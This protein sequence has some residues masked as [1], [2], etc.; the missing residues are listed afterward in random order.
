M[1]DVI[2]ILLDLKDR[3]ERQIRQH[4]CGGLTV[5]EVGLDPCA[6]N[7]KFSHMLHSQL[8]DINEAIELASA[9]AVARNSLSHS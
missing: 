9:A 5:S 2:E 1:D 7:R 6:A 4:E 3:V 8:I